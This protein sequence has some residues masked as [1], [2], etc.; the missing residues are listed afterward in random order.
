MILDVEFCPAVAAPTR[1]GVETRFAWILDWPSFAPN[2]ADSGGAT[3]G[4]RKKVLKERNF[5][6]FRWINLI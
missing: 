6:G 5:L 3:K 1:V 2:L 4:L